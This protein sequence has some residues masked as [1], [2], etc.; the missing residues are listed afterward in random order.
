MDKRADKAGEGFMRYMQQ[1]GFIS[2]CTYTDPEE[3]MG[4]CATEIIADPE[5]EEIV[6]LMLAMLISDYGQIC[7]WDEEAM[8]GFLMCL[9]TDAMVERFGESVCEEE[10]PSYRPRKAPHLRV[11]PGRKKD[12]GDDKER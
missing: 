6:E 3:D 7:D 10:D 5:D 2:L 1:L 12:S 9:M 4:D 11:L 8:M